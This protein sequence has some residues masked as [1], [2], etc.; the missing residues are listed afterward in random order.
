MPRYFIQGYLPI[1][2]PSH[3][4][5]V[6]DALNRH[7]AALTTSTADLGGSHFRVGE[8]IEAPTQD[9]AVSA[10]ESRI[11]TAVG[12]RVR[13]DRVQRFTVGTLV[14]EFVSEWLA[15]DDFGS[16]QLGPVR[17]LAHS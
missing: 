11:A 3:P 15:D 8:S 9:E 6:I 14:A 12:R 4:D 10:L 2:P 16:P 17:H 13:T 1:D 5:A 7:G